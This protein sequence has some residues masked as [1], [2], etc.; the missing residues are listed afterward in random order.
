MVRQSG[1]WG[2]LIFSLNLVDSA[3][4]PSVTLR[5]SRLTCCTGR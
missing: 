5:P 2:W 4:R 1:L 3:F